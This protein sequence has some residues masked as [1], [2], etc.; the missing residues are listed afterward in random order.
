MI[1]KHQQLLP[2]EITTDKSNENNAPS[3]QSENN[4]ISSQQYFGRI[5]VIRTETELENRGQKPQTIKP[6]IYIV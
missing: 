5:A 6:Q 1:M 2:F 4:T 3:F